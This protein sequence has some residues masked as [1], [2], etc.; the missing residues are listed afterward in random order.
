[1]TQ[2]SNLHSKGAK[3]R[4]FNINGIR[5]IVGQRGE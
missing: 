2:T 3:V 5:F 4:K 1:M